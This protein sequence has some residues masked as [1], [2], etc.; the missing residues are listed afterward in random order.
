M[1][2]LEQLL[3]SMEQSFGE[4]EEELGNE[5]TVALRHMIQTSAISDGN[6]KLPP[7]AVLN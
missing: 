3:V 7:D 2:H 4:Q 6:M 5:T 1:D